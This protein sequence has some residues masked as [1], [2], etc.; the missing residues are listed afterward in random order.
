MLPIVA[1]RPPATSLPASAAIR[2]MAAA[3]RQLVELLEYVALILRK[4]AAIS[5]AQ[6]SAEKAKTWAVVAAVFA[7]VAAVVLVVVAIVVTVFT[8]G[9]GAAAASSVIGPIIVAGTEFTSFLQVAAR[10]GHPLA[11]RLAAVIAQ[12]TAALRNFTNESQRDV[13]AAIQK[14]L[15]EI[16]MAL[17]TLEGLAAPAAR[18]VGPCS[19]DPKAAFEACQELS[20]ILRRLAAILQDPRFSRIAEMTAPSRALATARAAMVATGRCR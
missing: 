11:A 16:L 10:S 8:F 20:E 14:A 18:L 12:M 19:G 13:W 3:I 2:Q 6:E 1:Q 9:V 4:F 7:I 5:D 15:A 17:R